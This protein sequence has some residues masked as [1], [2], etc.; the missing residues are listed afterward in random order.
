MKRTILLFLIMAV[1]GVLT[2]CTLFTDEVGT[3]TLNIPEFGYP[4]FEAT[5]TAGGVVGGQYTF[6]VEGKTY[7]QPQNVKT[8]TIY[9][10]PCVVKV[11]WE[12]LKTRVSA[13]RA[14]RTAA[15]S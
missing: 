5:L 15:N 1:V 3:L 2:S 4:P 9:N 14:S 6:L 8:L 12:M 11:T 7:T 13:E 10:L